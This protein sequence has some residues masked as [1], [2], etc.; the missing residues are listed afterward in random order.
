MA[1]GSLKSA[2]PAQPRPRA[3]NKERARLTQEPA[4]R[5]KQMNFSL[6][7]VLAAVLLPYV[8]QAQPNKEP[9]DLQERCAKQ[10]D[11]LYQGT[12]KRWSETSPVSFNFEHHY[13]LA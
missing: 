11:E 6:S 8:G 9:Y 7:V 10:A 3:A 2:D 5:G 13:S 12:H 4:L 1:A